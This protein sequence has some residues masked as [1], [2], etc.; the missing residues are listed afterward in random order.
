MNTIFQRTGFDSWPGNWVRRIRRRYNDHCINILAYHRIANRRSALCPPGAPVHAPAEFERHMDYLAACFQPVGL[1]RVVQAARDGESLRRAVVVTLDDGWADSLSEAA[2]ITARR[3]IPIT[4]FPVTS[5]IGNADLIW[6]HKLAWLIS[7]GHGDR[8]IHAMSAA[9]IAPPSLDRSVAEHARQ[10][11]RADLPDIL[12]SVAR[13]AGTTGAA[14]AARYR[15]YVEPEEMAAADPDLIEFGNHTHRHVILSALTEGQQRREMESARDCID[16]IVGRAPLALAY[17]FGLK[18]HIGED[19][20]RLAVE[21]G[22]QAV[23]DLRR[24]VNHRDVDPLSL[25]RKPAPS[26]TQSEFERIVEDWPAN[27]EIIAPSVRR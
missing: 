26:G 19:S 2:L 21:T 3:G 25:S 8:V 15:P 16:A 9:G 4:I 1:R 23:L 14:L 17:P 11:F 6:Q 10:S 18:R 22:H 24:R 5:V 20:R 13:D 27:T 7:E 12:E